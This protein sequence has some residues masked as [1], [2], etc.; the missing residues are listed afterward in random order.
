[1]PLYLVYHQDNSDYKWITNNFD[2]WLKENNLLR[3][4]DMGGDKEL[5]EDETW[6]DILAFE[7]EDEFIVEEISPKQ[8]KK[9]EKIM[10]NPKQVKEIEKKY[11]KVIN[12]IKTIEDEII[13]ICKDLPHQTTH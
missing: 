10:F 2:A 6:E 9:K 5:D 1:M 8:V 3:F 4:K 7:D 12:N 11:K 13:E